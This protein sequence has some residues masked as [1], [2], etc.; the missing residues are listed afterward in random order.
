VNTAPVEVPPEELLDAPAPKP[1]K[2]SA[3]SAQQA[4]ARTSSKQNQAAIGSEEDD[5]EPTSL[6]GEE[7]ARGKSG[8]N[9]RRKSE[10]KLEASGSGKKRTGEIP[11][12]RGPRKS[13]GFARSDGMPEA[14]S[15]SASSQAIPRSDAWK[16]ASPSQRPKPSKEVE[17]SSDA[18]KRSTGGPIFLLVVLCVAGG[19]YAFKDQLIGLSHQAAA[20]P[21][22]AAAT[23]S[24]PTVTFITQP[25]GMDV[26]V[27][28][29]LMGQTPYT[30][31]PTQA[32]TI[33][34]RLVKESAGLERQID[35]PIRDGT[36]PITRSEEFA[37][38]RLALTFDRAG[39]E[40]DV[41]LGKTK[42][43]HAPGPQMILGEGQ[44]DLVVK[45]EAAGLNKTIKVTIQKSRLKTEMVIT[46]AKAAAPDDSD[47]SDAPN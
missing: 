30:F 32:G 2:R 18:P 8:P 25:E 9:P 28:N 12:S 33:R 17:A 4:A 27:D 34:V 44:H 7:P 13:S 41:Y 42:L 3:S 31:A 29:H 1:A 47:G 35:I 26:V 37:T 16:Q 24:L 43:G 23:S 22:A 5:D 38:G 20:A 21:V 39:M 40:G 15:R 19:A 6:D 46:R 11:A 10:D 36:P 14:P 45:N